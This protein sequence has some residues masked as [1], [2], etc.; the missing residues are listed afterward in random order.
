M[1]QPNLGVPPQPPHTPFAD[2]PSP[3]PFRPDRRSWPLRA[4]VVFALLPFAT[5]GACQTRLV[6]PDPGFVLWG[7]SVVLAL[8]AAGIGVFTLRKAAGTLERPSWKAYFALFVGLLSPPI[9]FFLGLFTASYSRGRALR[10]AG[11]AKLPALGEGSGWDAPLDPVALPEAAIE[12]WLAN[13]RTEVASVAAF[14]HLANELLAIGAPAHLVRGALVASLEEIE[15]AR[16]CFAIAGRGDVATFP[17]A[18]TSPDRKTTPATLAA[19]CVVEACLLEGAS[20]IVA[21]VLARNVAVPVTIAAVLAR[22]ANE[23]ASHAEHG[24]LVLRYLVDRHGDEVLVAARE[25]LRAAEH[26][27]VEAPVSDASLEAFGLPGPATWRRALE[28]A[29]R[30]ASRRLEAMSPEPARAVTAERP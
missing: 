12:G 4:A 9:T 21:D 13:A 2:R 18:T 7:I 27:H 26:R 3:S 14:N 6:A 15:H 25:A 24:W 20:A 23:E 17:E 22:I 19:D 29:W 28:E 8:V 10:R 1:G 30:R 5:Y 16:L 11:V